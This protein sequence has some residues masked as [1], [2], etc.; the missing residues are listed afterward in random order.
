[1][2]CFKLFN[3]T[4]FAYTLFTKCCNLQNRWLQILDDILNMIV[5]FSLLYTEY[6]I[7]LIR[8]NSW[9]VIGIE[10]IWK[11]LLLFKQRKTL[12]T[13]AYTVNRMNCKMNCK[14]NGEILW[15]PVH[16]TVIGCLHFCECGTPQYFLYTRIF[17]SNV[18]FKWSKIWNQSDT[19]YHRHEI[20]TVRLI[21]CISASI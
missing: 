12:I 8:L 14:I 1:M 15:F 20:N 11:V 13:L 5:P 3:S 9:I 18:W 10:I 6:L 4:L 17:T 21:Y 7:D 19:V 16:S 2:W